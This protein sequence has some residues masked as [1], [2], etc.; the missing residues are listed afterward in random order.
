MVLFEEKSRGKNLA[1]VIMGP[2]I[3]TVW[4]SFSCICFFSAVVRQAI[5]LLGSE[6]LSKAR[7]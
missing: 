7:V 2:F 3:M 5:V 6:S 1:G 4:G